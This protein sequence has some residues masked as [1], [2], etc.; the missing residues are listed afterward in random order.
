MNMAHGT[1]IAKILENKTMPPKTLKA[2]KTAQRAII[3]GV[4]FAV[5]AVVMTVLAIQNRE[6]KIETDPNNFCP[7]DGNLRGYSMVLLDTSDKIEDIAAKA[8]KKEIRKIGRDLNKYG[9]ISIFDIADTEKD[10]ISLCSPIKLSECSDINQ[11]CAN[12][13]N[14][15]ESQFES[16]LD[17]AMANVLSKQTELKSSPIIESIV[18]LSERT[19]FE[20]IVENKKLFIFS[21]MLQH[22]EGFSHIKGGAMPEN[23]F[24]DIKDK[25]NSIKANLEGTEVMIY[26]IKRNK[27]RHLQT[28]HHEIFWHDL[29][30]YSGAKKSYFEVFK[31]GGDDGEVPTFHA[32]ISRVV[33][34]KVNDGKSK[35]SVNVK[36][37]SQSSIKNNKTTKE[38]SADSDNPMAVAYNHYRQGKI[39]KAIEWYKKAADGGDVNAYRQLGAIYYTD[40]SNHEE[41]ITY[42]KKAAIGGHLTAIINLSKIYEQMGDEEES[43]YWHRKA[44]KKGDVESQYHLAIL[45]YN[46]SDVIGSENAKEAIHWLQVAAEK[47]HG[48][49]QSALGVI[50]DLGAQKSEIAEDPNEASTWYR[51]AVISTYDMKNKLAVS[52]YENQIKAPLSGLMELHIKDRINGSES[53]EI[54]SIINTLIGDKNFNQIRKQVGD[55]VSRG[56]AG[57]EKNIVVSYILYY[58]ADAE[59]EKIGEAKLQLS[60]AELTIAK[61]QIQKMRK[62]NQC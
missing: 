57:F 29:F 22:T 24:E 47:G 1:R 43:I 59:P 42:L 54:K 23:G 53:E 45:L 38:E 13:K 5:L 12:L 21:D 17:E 2:K 8:L 35:N 40:L 58:C 18:N 10:L 62:V 48:Q 44:A 14:E 9:K 49:A 34:P 27:Y 60:Q 56:L 20:K 55:L 37:H 26:Y 15:F 30:D 46:S 7:V 36:K 11:N 51:R 6:I 61:N 28:Q 39:K 31:H 52:E 3:G 32:K 16:K 33:K 25:Y 4:I 50:Y 41:G 19:D